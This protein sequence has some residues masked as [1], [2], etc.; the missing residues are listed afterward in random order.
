M[1]DYRGLK[2]PDGES[3]LIEWME[4][5]GEIV[6]GKPS[7]QVKKYRKALEYVT[8]RAACIDVGA[9][10]GLWS[11]VMQHD[12]GHVYAFEPVP[13]HQECWRLNVDPANATLFPHAV[14][15][16]PG[17]VRIA[18]P[19]PHSTGDTYVSSTSEGVR[20]EMVTLD[21]AIEGFSGIGL[22]KIDCEGYELHVLEGARELLLTAK[23]VVIVEQ[24]PG[25]AKQFGLPDTGAVD[26]LRKLGYHLREQM[27]GDYILSCP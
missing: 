11:R 18:T 15:A 6:H 2:L 14:G 12:F 4:K 13:D 26:Y 10:A 17:E 3:H 9:H 27:S 24:K 16:E 8:N 25:K 22:I 20:A 5:A 21:N 1:Q 19:D 23:P 7:Y